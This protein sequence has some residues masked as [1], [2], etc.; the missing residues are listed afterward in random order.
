[1]PGGTSWRSLVSFIVARAFSWVLM[2]KCHMVRASAA[3]QDAKLQFV[4]CNRLPH[5]F[6]FAQYLRRCIRKVFVDLLHIHWGIWLAV[7]MLVQLDL[8]VV[9]SWVNPSYADAGGERLREQPHSVLHVAAPLG[10]GGQAQGRL[11]AAPLRCLGG[12]KLD[13]AAGL[14]CKI[15]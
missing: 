9:T 1:M 7:A 10:L 12:C 3:Y 8:F 14:L 4:S 11:E 15:G 5:D 2:Y 6:D 13:L